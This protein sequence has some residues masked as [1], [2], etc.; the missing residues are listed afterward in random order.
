MFFINI[1]LITLLS[2]LNTC[3]GVAIQTLEVP[4]AVE[5]GSENVVLDCNYQY[6]DTEKQQLEVKWYFNEDPTPFFQWIAGK[7]ET[8]PQIIGQQFEDKLDLNYTSGSDNYTMYRALLLHKPT[9]DMA[10]TYTCKVSSFENED[11]QEAKMIVYSPITPVH[12]K[13]ARVD[14]SK[15]NVSC[16]FNGV[17]PLPNVKL[18]W[19]TF[20]LFEDCVVI[21]PHND[22]F[23]VMVYK[24]LEHSKLPSETV[25]GCEISIPGTEYFVREEAIYHHRG[26][27]SLEM[28]K[29]RRLEKVRQRKSKQ[30]VFYNTD[31]RIQ[32]DAM[33]SLIHSSTITSQVSQTTIAVTLAWLVLV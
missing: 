11:V 4:S 3:V 19:G 28:E 24:T 31:S 17:F 12:F 7:I 27:R 21:K 32:A 1:T 14:G 30:Q 15:V 10:G 33:E 13:Q 2:L 18:T 23:D 25:F 16:E 6:N 8:K 9:I 29:I 26:R 20:A 5:L 22:S